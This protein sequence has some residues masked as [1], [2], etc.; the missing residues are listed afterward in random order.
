MLWFREF[1]ASGK[2]TQRHVINIDVPSLNGLAVRIVHPHHIG[3]NFLTSLGRLR[4]HV[5]QT[6]HI[7]IDSLT[8]SWALANTRAI[9]NPTCC[10]WDACVAHAHRHTTSA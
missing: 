3:I 2:H 10:C 5:P 7:G 4:T 6:H 1:R 8:L 9:T